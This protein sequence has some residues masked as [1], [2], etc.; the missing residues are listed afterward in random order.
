M[1]RPIARGAA[2]IHSLFHLEVPSV[3]VVVRTCDDPEAG[4]EYTYYIPSVALD[5]SDQD[6]LRTRQTQILDML[7]RMD[8]PDLE[9]TARRILDRSDLHTAFL[10][11]LALGSSART[12]P[13]YERL[14]PGVGERHGEPVE[15]FAPAIAEQRR[16]Q[17]VFELRRAI[18]DP[19]LRFFL[20][21][22]LNLPDREA[23]DT[24]VRARY[25]DADVG[26][27]IEGWALSLAE[28]GRLGMELDP[29]LERL[30]RSCLR[31]QGDEEILQQLRATYSP[32]EVEEQREAVI[33]ACRRIR[34]HPI[35]RPLFA[36]PPPTPDRD[37]MPSGC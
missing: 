18:N 32:E 33:E 3:T 11:L 20:A 14:L 22:V 12:L 9:A 35:L 10:V 6:P 23:V 28:Q 7:V 34:R 27:R 36:T 1:V 16:R 21:L 17:Q 30:L 2:L 19:D 29:I 15:A 31:E 5:P 37:S 8:S 24:L 25:P 13:L 26:Q 4:P